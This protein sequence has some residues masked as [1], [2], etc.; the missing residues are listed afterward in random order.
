VTEKLFQYSKTGEGELPEA[1]LRPAWKI[2]VADDEPDVHEA[3]AYALRAVELE[4]RPLVL[5]HAYS[6]AETLEVLARHRDT[7]VV[8]L[9]AVMETET[10]GLDAIARIRGDLGLGAVRIIL[11]TGQPGYAPELVAIRDYDVDDY[12]SKA[13]LTQMRLI[14]ALTLAIRAFRKRGFTLDTFKHALDATADVIVMFDGIDGPLHYANH[15][16]GRM[17]GDPT[18]ATPLKGSL[19]DFLPGLSAEDANRIRR[20]DP[21]GVFAQALFVT[22]LRAVDGRRISVEARLQVVASPEGSGE[23]AVLVAR[24]LADRADLERQ[25]SEFLSLVS[26][27]LRTPLASVFGALDLLLQDA[28]T[29]ID[30]E[31]RSL[32]ELAHDSCGRLVR[33]ADDMLTVAKIDSGRLAYRVSS[34]PVGELLETAIA[35]FA[36]RDSG[37]A[38]PV[39]LADESGGLRVD[40][41]PD[42]FA[43]ILSNLLTNASRYS[44]AGTPVEIAAALADGGVS[45]GVVDHGPGVPADLRPRLFERFARAS[46][47]SHQSGSGLGLYLSRALARGMGGDLSCSD[48]A[49]GGATFHLRLPASRAQS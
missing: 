34:I 41:D 30:G 20:P 16:A 15:G 29:S 42:R 22:D 4:G 45:I 43:Q 14:S 24:N 31:D 32:L 27:E 3:T 13:E 26:H 6:A 19:R 5:L 39:I 47:E 9:D 46:G 18:G 44:P 25:K 33:L 17:L 28:A 23:V 8:L 11:R 2:L 49:G 37:R 7:S 35:E 12:R 21:S 40:V 36:A 48:T 38:A 10:A 1:P